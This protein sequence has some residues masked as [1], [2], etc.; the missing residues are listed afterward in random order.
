M[1]KFVQ[2][3]SMAY[4]YEIK[5]SFSITNIWKSHLKIQAGKNYFNAIV[6]YA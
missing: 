1:E 6:K 4:K 5:L 3:E 2:I